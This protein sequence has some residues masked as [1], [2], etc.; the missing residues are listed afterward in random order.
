MARKRLFRFLTVEMRE[1]VKIEVIKMLTIWPKKLE[2]ECINDYVRKICI[3]YDEI[4]HD[5]REKL[6]ITDENFYEKVEAVW[7]YLRKQVKGI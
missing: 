6:S 3:I 5:P 4:K 1:F 2:P 7:I